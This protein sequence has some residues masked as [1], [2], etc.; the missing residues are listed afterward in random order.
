MGEDRRVSAQL[1]HM[2]P[3]AQ[4]QNQTKALF[5]WADDLVHKLG[6]VQELF[7]PPPPHLEAIFTDWPTQRGGGV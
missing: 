4:L 7:F 6:P 3:H 2:E 1:L 5:P